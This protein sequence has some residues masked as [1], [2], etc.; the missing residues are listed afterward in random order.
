MSFILWDVPIKADAYRSTD[1][2]KFNFD[3]NELAF[4]LTEED[5]EESWSLSF[6]SY[7][8]FRTTT[9]ECSSK[10]IELLPNEGGFFKADESEWLNSLGKGEVPFLDDACHFIVCCYDEIIEV[11]ANKDSPK[12]LKKS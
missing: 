12:F 5:T 11:V 9:E 7:Q 3:R 2:E 4:T 8:A 10:V 1:L 6:D